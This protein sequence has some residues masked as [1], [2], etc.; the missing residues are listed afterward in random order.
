MPSFHHFCARCEQDKMFCKCPTLAQTVSFMV[1]EIVRV[2]D[3]LVRVHGHPVGQPEWPTV[4][5]VPVIQLMI[6][7]VR[8]G[9]TIAFGK[10]QH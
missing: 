9:D 10:Y 7:G 2:S 5:T 8:E 1:T 6:L 3:Q 4:M